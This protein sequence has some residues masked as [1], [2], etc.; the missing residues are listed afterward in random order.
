MIAAIF[1][2]VV[3]SLLAG[4]ILSM[5]RTSSMAFALDVVSYKALLAADSG[6][7][8][9]LNR[10]YAPSGIGTC[11]DRTW[12]LDMAGLE[13]CQAIVSCTS[14]SVA[15]ETFY[16]FESAGRCESGSVIAER[17]IVIRSKS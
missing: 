1:L 16:T 5:V 13:S 3:V 11:V 8:L 10:L 15:S 6:A 2:I 7:Q 17:H 12:A 4:A 9:S 14:E